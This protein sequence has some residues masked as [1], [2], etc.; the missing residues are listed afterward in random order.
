VSGASGSGVALS[1]G[2]RV[3]R[4]IERR[5]DRS[6][7]AI[8]IAAGTAGV[9][10][11]AFLAIERC[12]AAQRGAIGLYL[13][14][15]LAMLGFSAAY[16]L[17]RDPMRRELFRKFDHA[18]IYLL[19]AGTYTPFAVAHLDSARGL[20]LTIL[21]WAVALIG[22]ATK[23]VAVR[24][25][26]WLSL[27]AYLLLGWIEFL[28]LQPE[29]GALDPRA[30]HLIIAGGLLYTGGVAFHLWRRLP[31]HIALWHGAVLAAAACHYAAVLIG[32]A[33]GGCAT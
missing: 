8:G 22:A 33:I 6:V 31:Y 17:S 12:G 28:G 4:E 21:A 24:R 27:A 14:S 16:H 26:E 2:P 7:H 18:A 20:S 15:L 3:Y 9:A 11:L 1:G 5:V 29:L 13:A 23:F 32:V 19:I 25:F 10:P 30:M